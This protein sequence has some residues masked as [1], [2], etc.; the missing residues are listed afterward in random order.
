MESA[1]LRAVKHIDAGGGE[2]AATPAR[3]TRLYTHQAMGQ[4]DLWT[5]EV[6]A[7]CSQGDELRTTLAALRRLTRYVPVDALHTRLEIADFF[8]EKEKY[9]I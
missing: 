9:E 3:M 6:L 7:A 2:A 4:I 8:K 1:Y 5:R